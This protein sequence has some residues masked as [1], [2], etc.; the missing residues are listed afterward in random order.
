MTELCEL[1]AINSADEK[2]DDKCPFCNE[3]AHEFESKKQ[4]PDAKV[5]SKPAQ[6]NCDIQRRSDG[7]LPYTTAQHHLI[8]ALQ[9]YGQIRRLVRMGSSV[10]YDINEPVNGIGL[11]TTHWTLKYDHA[12]KVQKFGDFNQTEKQFIAFALMNERKDQ[13]HVGH[14]AFEVMIPQLWDSWDEDG[15]DES[16]DDD[17]GHS[18]QY[19][20][21]ITTRLC[22]IMDRWVE[23]GFCKKD[24]DKSDDLKADMDK[25]SG[26]IRDKLGMFAT[27]TPMRS[28]PLFVSYLAYE[29]AKSMDSSIKRDNFESDSD[30]S[31][32]P[33]HPAPRP[34]KRRRT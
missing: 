9:C 15:G 16:D 26:E 29:Y 21:T 28:S 7:K 32:A 12:G 25:L 3:D 13:W 27:S 17:R 8:S 24:E 2:S 34:S 33:D 6:L 5:K 10:G 30:A 19:D 31:A 18:A 14:H 22:K 11:T 23:G 20:T 4:E 1:V